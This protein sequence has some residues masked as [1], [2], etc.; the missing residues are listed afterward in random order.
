MLWS[1]PSIPR[2]LLPIDSSL[3][4]LVSSQ[5]TTQKDGAFLNAVGPLY[6]GWPPTQFA[7]DQA[8]D[9][10]GA[11]F[12]ERLIMLRV[13]HIGPCDLHNKQDHSHG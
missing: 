10:L 3:R 4:L 2:I 8:E 6:W 12:Y 5:E 13:S 11:L 1:H 9:L 7:D